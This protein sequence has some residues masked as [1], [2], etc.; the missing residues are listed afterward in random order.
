M[1]EQSSG[2]QIGYIH[3][4][5]MGRSDIN[6]WVEEFT[7]IYDRAGL[8]IDVRHNRGGNIDSWI[9]G[10]LLRKAW[11]Y[12]QPRTGAPSWNMQEAFRGHLVL[13]C[14]QWTASD[15]EAFSAGFHELGLGKTIGTRTWGGEIWLTGSNVLADRGVATAAELGVYTQKREWLIEGHGF[16]PDIVVD[17]LPHATFEGKDAQLEAALAHLKH[18]IETD[19]RPVPKPP[20]YPDKSFHSTK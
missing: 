15:G 16:E 11:M 10:K 1:V 9:L 18:L 17:D 4:R 14:D 19:P 7:P 2:G 8:V 6:R 3:L 13:L 5:A 12:W 20:D